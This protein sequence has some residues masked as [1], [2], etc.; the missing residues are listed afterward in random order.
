M[1]RRVII[2]KRTNNLMMNR[3][4]KEIIRAKKSYFIEAFHLY[5]NNSKK[6]CKLLHQLIGMNKTKYE[7]MQLLDGD[8]LLIMTTIIVV[9]RWQQETNGKEGKE[10]TKEKSVWVYR[11]S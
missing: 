3:I 5:K 1:Y 8:K 2:S 10:E 4:T 6:S 9:V 7:I 11:G